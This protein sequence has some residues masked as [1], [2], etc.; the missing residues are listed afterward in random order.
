[1]LSVSNIKQKSKHYKDKHLFSCHGII[2][3]WESFEKCALGKYYAI[4]KSK[5]H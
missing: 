1:M 3:S 5:K 4:Q 2:S